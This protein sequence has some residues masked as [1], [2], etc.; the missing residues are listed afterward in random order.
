MKLSLETIETVGFF[1]RS[2]EA[3]VAHAGNP[4]GPN[5]TQAGV[6]LL[7]KEQQPAEAVNQAELELILA[8]HDL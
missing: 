7:F 6:G 2:K 1:N 5:E 8:E 3:S 4:Y